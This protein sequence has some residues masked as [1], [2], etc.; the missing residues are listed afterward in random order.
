LTQAQ[1]LI[2]YVH[3][4][5]FRETFEAALDRQRADHEATLRTL[6]RVGRLRRAP[7]KSVSAQ[8]AGSP[9][10]LFFDEV[11]TVVCQ[12]FLGLMSERGLPGV[13]MVSR[14]H[15]EES[16]RGRPRHF[17]GGVTRIREVKEPILAGYTIGFAFAPDR[18]T[19]AVL[20]NP[21]IVVATPGPIEGISRASLC[22]DQT[23]RN[24]KCQ[25]IPKG[26]VLRVGLADDNPLLWPDAPRPDYPEPPVN[27]IPGTLVG[28]LA[29]I[30]QA[31]ERRR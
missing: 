22:V 7:A 1:L 2:S 5:D 6:K 30:A 12:S 26:H 17:E 19:Q 23:I 27:L 8:V 31:T 3:M 18:V 13:T 14:S 10:G 21:S 15:D 25:P 29:R 20:R 24:D 28:T 16:T 11:E 9:L 4:S